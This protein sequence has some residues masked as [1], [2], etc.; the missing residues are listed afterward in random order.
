MEWRT[1]S[2]CRFDCRRRGSLFPKGVTRRELLAGPLPPRSCLCLHVDSVE[3]ACG[4]ICRTPLWPMSWLSAGL[5]L[6]LWFSGSW[7][8]KGKESSSSLLV[9]SDPKSGWKEVSASVTWSGG[10]EQLVP[11]A[12][13]FCRLQTP[14]WEAS[15]RNN[16]SDG[17]A[18]LKSVLG[19]Q[20]PLREI[21]RKGDKAWS[22]TSLCSTLQLSPSQWDTV[23]E[24]THLKL[25]LQR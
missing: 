3:E 4:W 5:W 6:E 19:E 9:S 1:V 25:I 21:E 2:N 8:R 7:S 22:L 12:C 16:H 18:W 11:S 24:E 10:S 17:W 14:L 23:D 15:N 20:R 13:R